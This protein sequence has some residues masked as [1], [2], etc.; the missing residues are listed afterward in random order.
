M[1]TRET[2]LASA[3]LLLRLKRPADKHACTVSEVKPRLISPNH[4]FRYAAA[5]R[6]TVGKLNTQLRCPLRLERR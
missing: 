2:T 4:H 3:P 5:S 1:G 6:G